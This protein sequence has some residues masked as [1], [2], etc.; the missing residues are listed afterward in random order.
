ML[1]ALLGI[2]LE[3]IVLF[4]ISRQV[5]NQLFTILYMI[6][7]SKTVAISI[8]TLIQ[9]PGT[10]IHELSHLFTAEILGVHTGKITL[11][12]I[13]T[14]ENNIQTG[15]VQVAVTDPFRRTA[16]GIAPVISGIIAITTIA[17]FLPSLIINVQTA[18][19]MSQTFTAPPLYILI[20]M[21]YF[22]FSISTAMFSSKEDMKGVIPL[23]ITLIIFFLA[24]YI[25]GIRIGLTDTLT[26]QIVTL[27][28][29]LGKSLGIV[30]G[31]NLFTLIIA[32]PIRARMIKSSK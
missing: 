27:L 16:I 18:W 22:M 21:C 28:Y 15:S 8:I 25:L 4:F 32:S 9:F 29:T 13:Q 23:L 20:A 17:Y 24:A 19:N 7:R 30:I 12:P 26:N 1:Y 11:V 10:V 5:T 31:I 3:M 6:F 2:I 14:E